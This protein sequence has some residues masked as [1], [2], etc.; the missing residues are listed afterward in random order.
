MSV[1]VVTEL[2]RR[3]RPDLAA[4]RPRG[5]VAG[6]VWDAVVAAGGAVS[7]AHIAHWAELDDGQVQ[8]ALYRLIDRGLMATAGLMPYGGRGRIQTYRVVEGATPCA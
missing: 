6:L 3:R 5:R 8:Y 4:R 7:V 1:Q 2:A